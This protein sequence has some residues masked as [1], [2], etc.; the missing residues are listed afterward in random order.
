MKIEKI[1]HISINVKSLDEAVKRF[2][3]VLGT[4][5]VYPDEETTEKTA[6]EY[7]DPALDK[8]KLR[9]AMDQTG[10]LTLVESN[11]PLGK[12]GL[13]SIYFKVPDLEQAKEEI[14]QKGI[15]L[16][17]IAKQGSMKE[18]TFSADDLH[19]VRLILTEYEGPTLTD[20]T[21]Q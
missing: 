8:T 1:E 17:A 7:A 5:F 10:C 11:P 14:K 16:T 12:E 18:A 2:S 9:E 3:G 15:R 13:R 19:G 21:L 4:T 6:T 20:A